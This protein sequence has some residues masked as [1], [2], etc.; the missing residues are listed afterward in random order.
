MRKGEN[1]FKRKDGRWE[2]RYIKGYELSGKI[3]YGFC[4]GKTY[5]EAK[6]KVTKC[7]AALISEKPLPSANSRHRFAFYCDEWLRLRKTKIRE[8][9]YIKYDTILEKHIKPKLGGCYPL[10]IT[11][12]LVDEFSKELLDADKLSVKTVHDILVV[13]HGILKYTAAQFPGIFP[14]VEINYPKETR[15]EMRV[16]SRDEQKRLAVYLLDD[17][18][19]C[20][21]GVLLMLFTGLRIGELC[22]LRW[23]DVN[24]KEKVISVSATMAVTGFITIVAAVLLCVCIHEFI[25]MLGYKLCRCNCVLV[26]SKP[27]ITIS[28]MGSEWLTKKQALFVT[29][30]P[31]LVIDALSFF[32]FLITKNS[33]LLMWLLLINTAL[34]GSDLVCVFVLAKT[35]KSSLTLGHYMRKQ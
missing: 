31:F 21:F 35:P 24:I 13:L 32:V 12:G 18:D 25:H 19:F 7:K 9:T 28:V 3:K 2:A 17:T 5:K 8:S 29:L 34:A 4:Y 20:K 1:I 11:A 16:L 14:A 22:A 26:Y 10:G 30:L 23:S 15:K 33:L 27:L 6:E